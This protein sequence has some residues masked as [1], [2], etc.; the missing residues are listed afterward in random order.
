MLTY[1][2]NKLLNNKWMAI[3]LIIGN[4][5][6][7]S[8]MMVSPMYSD[9]S[10]Q[11]MLQRSL[12]E[13]MA[14][15]NQYPGVV[16]F[17]GSYTSNAIATSNIE[18]IDML[19]EVVNEFAQKVP[20]PVAYQVSEYFKSEISA[21]HESAAL[22][23]ENASR[24]N[25]RIDAVSDFDQHIE[26]LSGDMPSR[27]MQGTVIEALVSQYTLM[28]ANLFI[29]EELILDRLANAAG[30]PY[31]IKVTGVFK[32]LKDED[33]FWFYNPNQTKNFFYTYQEA[34]EEAFVTDE[35]V[36]Q[37]FNKTFYVILDYPK[38]QGSNVDRILKTMDASVEEAGALFRSG[39]TI[40]S[41]AT[42]TEYIQSAKRLSVTLNVLQVPILLL[43]MAF[44]FMVSSQML[45]MDQN[46][47]AM[48]K[49]RGAGRGQ[50]LGIYLLQSAL[51]AGIAFLISLPLSYLICQIIGSANAFLEFVQRRA[52]PV[53]WNRLSVWIYGIGAVLICIMAMVIPAMRYA[54]VGIVEFK[55]SKH[56]KTR[57]LW[58][59]LFLDVILL[60]VSLYGL[61]SYHH[62][63]GFLASSLERGQALDPLL[64]LCSSLFV[65]GSALLFAR[66]F[67]WLIKLIFKAGEKKWSPGIYAS[68]LRMMRSRGNQTFIMIFLVI[69]MAMGIFSAS[70]AQT[71]NTN[72]ERQTIYR[73][74]ADLVLKEDWDTQVYVSP[75]GL[76]EEVYTE[77]DYSRYQALVDEGHALSYTKVF[78]HDGA[79]LVLQ[80]GQRGNVPLTVLAVSTKE[81]GETANFEISLLK[82]HW[83]HYLNAISQDPQGILVSTVFRDQLGYKLGDQLSFSRVGK[84]TLQGTI[85]GFVDYFPSLTPAT[86]VG[87]AEQASESAEGG[88]SNARG[89]GS[90]AQNASSAQG[91]LSGGA[92]VISNL[93]FIQSK[94]GVEPYEVWIKNASDSSSYIYDFAA[95]HNMRF[96]EFT[97]TN[98]DMIADKNNPVFQATNG[99]LTVGFIMVLILCSVGF[100]I[101][102]V[103]SIWSR[104]L[105]F[106]IFR[107]MGMT[108]REII[109]MLLNEQF[110]LS[111]LSI[112][113][114][115]LVGKLTSRLFVPLIQTAYSTADQ[116]LPLRVTSVL[117]DEIRLYIVVGLVLI[118]CIGVLGR[119]VQKIKIAQAL[120]LGED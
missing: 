9:A 32:T 40:R 27:H 48:I 56:K 71:I 106:G 70:I 31:K 112:V 49:S 68:F 75:S 62:Q 108:L 35:A 81:F 76:E 92:F 66:I 26:L 7:V 39:T 47:I 41:Y 61:Y 84:A 89:S 57:P 5:L 83:Y 36:R 13:R 51:I 6:L 67:P 43:V 44:I 99:I 30:E 8:I 1:V 90:N 24:I 46:E 15:T 52:L 23:Q 82:D 50:I 11:R 45:S 20:A 103:L 91:A 77:P 29:G 38:M 55:R 98:A 79:K 34:F 94:W 97:D 109:G 80:S 22:N 111:V 21:Y 42:L 120:K 93:S 2:K 58:E 105:Q 119:L 63:A 100:L 72:Q 102:W 33:P 64:Y 19:E 74:G 65:L 115:A 53:R 59:R 4:I 69:T 60:G 88:T 116:W 118:I 107:A 117:G 3:S 37:P 114:G 104:Q 54:K 86:Y 28:S 85:Y 113:V 101:Y 78:R 87:G 110:F 17:R 12:T 25:S 96:S 95:K 14:Q 16:E 18:K 73:N 10:L